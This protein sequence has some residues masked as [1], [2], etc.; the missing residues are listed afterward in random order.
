[1]PGGVESDA[2]A[3][4]T[5][6]EQGIVQSELEYYIYQQKYVFKQFPGPHAC[7]HIRISP[8]R[9]SKIQTCV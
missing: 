6:I 4:S 1:M 9:R 8:N 5:F 3:D 7:L 2:V